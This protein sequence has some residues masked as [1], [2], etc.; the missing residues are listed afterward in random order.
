MARY[1]GPVCKLCRREGEKLFL[2]GARCFTAKCSF[3]KRSYAPGQHGATR[4]AKL[5]E[6][7]IQLREKQKVKRIYGVLEAQFRNYYKKASRQKGITGENLLQL[8]ESRLD[9]VIYRLGFAPSRK[10]ARQ[11]VLHRHFMVNGQVVNIPSYTVT[12]GDKITVREKSRKLGIIHEALKRTSDETLVPWLRVDKAKMEG[13]F[14][15]KPA[16]QDIPIEVQEN[17]IVELYSK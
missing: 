9:N 1:T 8:L 7:G 3:E 2:K 14:L 16:R 17:L 13:E 10:A 6:Y 12:P 5:S 4:R 11:L 15:E